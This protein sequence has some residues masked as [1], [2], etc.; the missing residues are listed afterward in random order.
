[1]IA[2]GTIVS[3]E[4]RLRTAALI[5]VLWGIGHTVTI[6][7]A[8]RRYSFLPVL[9]DDEAFRLEKPTTHSLA[10]T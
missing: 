7:V 1:M 10:T 4:R 5:G 8:G 6:L 3:R 9:Y 2:V